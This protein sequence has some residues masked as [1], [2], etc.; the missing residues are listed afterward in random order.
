MFPVAGELDKAVQGCNKGYRLCNYGSLA[1]V[2]VFELA[3]EER[4]VASKQAKSN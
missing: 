1:L 2:T 3:V 4:E